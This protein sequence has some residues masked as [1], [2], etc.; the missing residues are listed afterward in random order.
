M[1][2]DIERTVRDVNIAL[3][4]FAT[5]MDN[6]DF[7]EADR[8]AEKAKKLVEMLSLESWHSHYTSGT[9]VI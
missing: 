3:R 8:L 1:A 9:G 5:A 6:K 7:K 2:L 4:N